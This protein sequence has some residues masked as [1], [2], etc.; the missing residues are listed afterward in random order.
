GS[1][2]LRRLTNPS[3]FNED[4]PAT[5]HRYSPMWRLGRGKCAFGDTPNEAH[6]ALGFRILRHVS[7]PI[8]QFDI[9]PGDPICH[10]Q[11][12]PLIVEHA[13]LG[14]EQDTDGHSQFIVSRFIPF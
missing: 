13:V 2:F 10:A 8:E 1:G 7:D 14:A 11:S 6:N 9:E 4:A 12:M 5:V 3:P